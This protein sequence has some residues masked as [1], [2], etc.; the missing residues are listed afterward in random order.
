MQ[1]LLE[2]CITSEPP[3]VKLLSIGVHEKIKDGLVHRNLHDFTQFIPRNNGTDAYIRRSIGRYFTQLNLRLYKREFHA[4]S[5][6]SFGHLSPGDAR[7]Y[8][9]ELKHI[10]FEN[11]RINIALK[12]DFIRQKITASVIQFHTEVPLNEQTKDKR[13]QIQ[14]N[15]TSE[16]HTKICTLLMEQGIY[17]DEIEIIKDVFLIIGGVT[18]QE[19]HSD[20]PRT[21]CCLHNDDGIAEISFEVNRKKYND[22]MTAT[23]GH[24]SMIS[25][26]DDNGF[27][28]SVPSCYLET[29]SIN[30]RVAAKYGKK[31]ETFSIESK[32]KFVS[33]NHGGIKIDMTTIRIPTSGC[34]FAGDL[35][36][37]GA[38][39]IRDLTDPEI[40]Q[41]NDFYLEA[42]E[43]ILNSNENGRILF[44]T[45]HSVTILPKISRIFVRII[46]RLHKKLFIPYGNIHTLHENKCQYVDRI[47]WNGEKTAK[48]GRGRPKIRNRMNNDEKP[49]NAENLIPV[50]DDRKEATSVSVNGEP[51]RTK[52]K[53]GRPK[54]CIDSRNSVAAKVYIDLS[55]SDDDAVDRTLP[56]ID[57]SLSNHATALDDTSLNQIPQRDNQSVDSQNNTVVDDA[58][59]IKDNKLTLFSNKGKES[60]SFF[61]LDEESMEVIRKREMSKEHGENQSSV[62]ELNAIRYDDKPLHQVSPQ[63]NLLLASE[64][65]DTICNELRRLQEMFASF[66]GS[67]ECSNTTVH[68]IESLRTKLEDIRDKICRELR[69]VQEAITDVCTRT[70]L[71]AIESIQNDLSDLRGQISKKVKKT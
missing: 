16:T 1:Q 46:P 59:P 3:D 24:R 60:A 27:L 54:K 41:F 15:S 44:N 25:G 8:N 40:K 13:I 63:N 50:A 39:N 61:D 18:D 57:L 19:P 67:D 36:H 58:E 21:Y 51:T 69:R 11:N 45:L 22:A 10:L 31:G 2:S 64:N 33:Y 65:I 56:A 23:H 52:R 34:K 37:S 43:M 12:D 68:I 5:Q 14:F 48:R 66:K 35:M 7:T 4:S 42:S 55:L 32:S 29:P 62:N 17:N 28:L 6:I 30:N 70:M 53:R 71:G 47:I 9:E 26:F 20:F 49:I 38:N